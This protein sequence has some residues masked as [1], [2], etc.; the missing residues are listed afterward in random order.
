MSSY[1]ISSGGGNGGCLLCVVQTVFTILKCADLI[2]WPWKYV[3][4]PTLVE[5]GLLAVCSVILFAVSMIDIIKDHIRK[6]K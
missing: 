2:D 6:R 4:L 1:S 3:L 5:L